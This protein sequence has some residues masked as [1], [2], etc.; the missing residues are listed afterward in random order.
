MS[1]TNREFFERLE[2]GQKY[3]SCFTTQEYYDLIPSE[4]QEQMLIN[5]I[6]QT[7]NLF[8]DDPIHKSLKSTYT[9][10][11]TALR[12]YEYDINHQKKKG[13]ISRK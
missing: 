2:D 10:S 8:I 4:V 11:K 7:N 3:L 13:D 9:K 1:I 12:N 6:R 5:E